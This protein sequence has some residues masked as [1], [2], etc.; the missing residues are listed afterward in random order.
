MSW[1]TFVE[2]PEAFLRSSCCCCGSC[3]Y[4]LACLI[5]DGHYYDRGSCDYSVEWSADADH[6]SSAA[7]LVVL[8]HHPS[9]RGS[10]S[11]EQHWQPKPHPGGGGCDEGVELLLVVDVDEGLGSRV[12]EMTV[13][14][15]IG[16]GKK[17][18]L[19]TD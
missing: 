12:G 16:R 10:H 17:V 11:C 19:E 1:H 13:G 6:H 2:R 18:E 7:C 3:H 5:Y 15:G 9:H 14:E 4:R 8:R